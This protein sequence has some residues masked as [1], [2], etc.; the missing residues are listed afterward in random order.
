MR[1]LRRPTAMALTSV[2][3]AA[4][5]ATVLAVRGVLALTG[6]P[7][8]GGNGLHIAHVLWGGLL[9]TVSLLAL[10]GLSGPAVRSAGAVVGGAGF[11]LSID[12]IG[13]FITADYDYFFHRAAVLV[14]VA[15]AAIVVCARLA[16]RRRPLSENE[17]LAAAAEL[18]VIGLGPG[19]TDDQVARAWH[20]LT[21]SGAGPGSAQIAD[22]LAQARRRPARPVERI[23]QRMARV[24]IGSGVSTV[25]VFTG[26]T[27][28]LLVTFG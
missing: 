6:Y 26:M 13:K 11:G 18:A 5:A 14:Y 28:T 7:Q 9:M 8:L 20:H 3:V 27:V 22:L 15:L 2:F 21:Q 24:R 16:Y 19:L 10:L 25:A 23:L 1:H 17:H 12:E 4:A